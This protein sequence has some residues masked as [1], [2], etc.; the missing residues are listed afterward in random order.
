MVKE[1]LLRKGTIKEGDMKDYKGIKNMIVRILLSKIAFPSPFG[2]TSNFM[3]EA[4]L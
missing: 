2:F 1:V 4:K 3:I